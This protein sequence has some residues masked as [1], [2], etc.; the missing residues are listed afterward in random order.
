MF[1]AYFNALILCKG[2]IF[3]APKPSFARFGGGDNG[4][5][6]FVLVMAH[7]LAGRIVAAER[8][9]TGLAGAQVHPAAAMFYTFSA[10]VFFCSLYFF[11]T[12]QMLTEFRL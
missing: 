6:G 5:A 7:V 2:V 1:P 4:V 3:N 10:F 8:D 12:L 9:A 11:K